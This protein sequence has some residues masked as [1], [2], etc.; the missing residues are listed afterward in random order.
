M[1]NTDTPALHLYWWGVFYQWVIMPW[2]EA[3][4]RLSTCAFAWRGPWRDTV[5]F[6]IGEN[7]PE[8]TC[9]YPSLS[10]GLWGIWMGV[11]VLC[12]PLHIHIHTDVHVHTPHYTSICTFSLYYRWWQLSINLMQSPHLDAPYMYMTQTQ[13]LRVYN[14]GTYWL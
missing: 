11:F 7:A 12:R 10:P 6:L 9:R 2:L 14:T 13:Y 1:T 4:L 8:S 5:R 3:S